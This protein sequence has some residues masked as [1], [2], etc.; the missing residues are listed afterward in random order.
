MGDTIGKNLRQAAGRFV[1]SGIDTA[2]LDAEVL[3][4]H[5]L[6]VDRIELHLQKDRA[7]T[8]D[9]SA[10]FEDYVAR[11]SK[12]EPVAYITGHREFW[13]LNICVTPDVLIP[14]PETELIVDLAIKHFHVPSLCKGGKGRV[15][16]PPPASPL[17]RGR[18]DILDLCTGSGCVAAALATELPDA[19]IT[20]ADISPAAIDIAKRNLAFAGDRIRFVIG[21]LFEPIP[22]LCKEGTG[23]VDLPHLPSPYKGEVPLFDLITANPPYVSDGDFDTLEDDIRLYEPQ[24]ALTAGA[25]GLAI[26][27]RIIQ[28][29]PKYLKPGGTLIMEM[30]LGQAVD[31]QELAKQYEKIEVVEDYSGIERILVMKTFLCIVD[32]ES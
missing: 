14:R 24:S 27:K 20:V 31:L 16:L 9:E 32:R 3:L 17:Q 18:V 7:L 29:A 12:R 23:E 28:D 11:R 6:N 10:R 13:S 2:A 30:G 22:L 5:T 19:A 25:D 15:D 1:K 4:A 26:S 21:D 8:D